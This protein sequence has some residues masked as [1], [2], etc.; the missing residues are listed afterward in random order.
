VAGAPPA[1]GGSAG[2]LR[3]AGPGGEVLAG[4]WGDSGLNTPMTSARNLA[5]LDVALR[6]W[7]RPHLVDGFWLGQ[8]PGPAAG[9]TPGG[10]N[11]SPRRS[12][13]AVPVNGD[14]AGDPLFGDPL[15]EDRFFAGCLGALERGPGGR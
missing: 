14:G 9:G 6:G 12:A 15:A 13:R 8:V 11:G 1:H 3:T 2:N 4:G 10:A 7:G 5:A